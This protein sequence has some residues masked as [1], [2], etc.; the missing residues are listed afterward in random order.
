MPK[1]GLLDLIL[2]G[3]ALEARDDYGRDVLGAHDP[4]LE[5]SAIPNL[6]LQGVRG[7]Q[8][9]KLADDWQSK[10]RSAAAGA[11][12][13][14]MA[15]SAALGLLRPDLSTQWRET[16]DAHPGMAIAGGLLGP[17]AAYGLLSRSLP[18]AKAVAL[19]LMPSAAA[20]TLNSVYDATDTDSDSDKKKSKR[21]RGGA[22]DDDEDDE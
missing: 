19:G 4:H 12:D 21:K 20:E 22:Q 9:L 6:V 5:R 17:A 2:R 10:L 13:P 15:P 1:N 7:R 14:F 16:S 8:R 11:A 3:A 18:K